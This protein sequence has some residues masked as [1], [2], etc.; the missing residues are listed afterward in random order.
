MC[1]CQEELSNRQKADSGNRCHPGGM[2][3]RVEWS[4][5]VIDSSVGIFGERRD[6]NGYATLRHQSHH[7]ERRGQKTPKMIDGAFEAQHISDWE[8]EPKLWELLLLV[9][10]GD[11]LFDFTLSVFRSWHAVLVGLGDNAAYLQ[12][13]TAIRKWDFHGI[14]IQHFMGYPYAIVAVS[15]VLHLPLD[16]SLSF[17]ASMASQILPGCKHL[18]WGW[19][20]TSSGCACSGRI[21]ELPERP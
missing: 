6:R 18:S 5:R 19:F 8:R 9:A 10:I 16:F 4:C 21:L 11:V 14:D 20:R 12:V 3:R 1:V 13:A 2:F 17:L 15:L 7:C